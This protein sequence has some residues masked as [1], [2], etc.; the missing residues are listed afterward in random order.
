MSLE[1]GEDNIGMGAGWIT[2]VCVKQ[3]RL[4][5]TVLRRV[6]EVWEVQTHGAADLPG[7]LG[8]EGVGAALRPKIKS[9]RGKL[10]VA[11]PGD[12]LLLRVALLPSTD[13]DELQGMAELQ[14]DRYSPFPVETMALGAESVQHTETS[15]L[16]AMAAVRREVIDDWGRG[17]QEAGGLPDVVDVEALGWWWVLKQAAQVPA[18]GSQLLV[19]L[20]GPDIDM[21]LAR[22]GAPLLYRSLPPRPPETDADSQEAWL[23]ECIEETGYSLTSL[24]TE[25]GESAAPTL[26]VFHEPGQPADWADS[27][28]SALGLEGLFTHSL[29]DLPPVSEGLAR[30][31]ADPAQPLAMDLTPAEWRLAD[32]ERA[33]RR[34]VLRAVTI[35]MAVWLLGLGVF[36][37]LLNIQRGR[38]ARLQATVEAMEGPA[39]TIRRLRAKVRE[40]SLYADRSHSALEGLRVLSEHL[41]AGIDLTSFVYRKGNTL[42]LRGE[43]DAQEKVYSFIQTL[44]QTGRFPEVKFEGVNTR[45]TPQGP[46]SQF[47]VTI[48]LPGSEDDLS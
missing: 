13:P 5:W 33:V 6:K 44:D 11:L 30:R 22:D 34:K 16:V 27:F 19:R 17:F 10:V 9:F 45:N 8:G 39:L 18:H 2:G 36:W 42:S 43:A 40:F 7:P 15:A 41:P 37:S 1:N 47:S 20:E 21:I 38:L 29:A 32:A 35:F 12:Q 4:E 25:W 31:A 46:R 24:E 3:D 28:R 14:T 23:A 48:R 26:H